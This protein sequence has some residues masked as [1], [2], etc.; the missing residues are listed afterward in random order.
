MGEED[1]VTDSGKFTGEVD[2]GDFTGE[3]EFDKGK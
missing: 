3:V 2:T 1:E